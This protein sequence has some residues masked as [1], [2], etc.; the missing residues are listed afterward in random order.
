M[1]ITDDGNYMDG[2][3]DAKRMIPN[4]Q[5]TKYGKVTVAL[6][7]KQAIVD[8]FEEEF[9][10]TD[11]Q[12]SFLRDYSYNCGMVAALKEHLKDNPDEE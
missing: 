7:V 12:D 10:Y 4:I 1:K 9:G 11:E 5:A 8:N 2:M 6:E 3:W